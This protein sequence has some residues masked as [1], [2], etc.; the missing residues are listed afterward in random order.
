VKRPLGYDPSVD[1][2]IL[3]GI[4]S[5]HAV[6]GPDEEPRIAVGRLLVPDPE[7]R[8]GWREFYVHR[9]PEDKPGRRPLGFGKP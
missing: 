9:P 8:G 1:S 2:A 3:V 7:Q 6:S 4:G 5:A